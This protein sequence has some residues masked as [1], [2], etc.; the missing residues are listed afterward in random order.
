MSSGTLIFL[1]LVVG[2]PLAMMLMHRGGHG[3]G[4]MGGCGMGHGGHGH[5]GAGHGDHGSEPERG[6]DHEPILGKPGE[7][8]RRGV[9]AP[10]GH[11]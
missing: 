4:G 11:V 1:L 9:H 6:G 3:A 8:V 2:V 10:H 7:P 5:G